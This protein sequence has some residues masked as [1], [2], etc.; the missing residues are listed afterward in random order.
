ME[1]CFAKSQ[2]RHVDQVKQLECTR[3]LAEVRQS[4]SIFSILN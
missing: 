2:V 3:Q 1:S 4:E